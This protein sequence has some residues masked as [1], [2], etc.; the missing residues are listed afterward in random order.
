[1]NMFRKKKWSYFAETPDGGFGFGCNARNIVDMLKQ[2][3][4][5]VE[6]QSERKKVTRLIIELEEK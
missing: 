2:T 5:Q 4:Y 3:L 6:R 1:M